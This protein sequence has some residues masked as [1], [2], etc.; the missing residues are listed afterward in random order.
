MLKKKILVTT[1]MMI[2]DESRFRSWLDRLGY[3][4]EFV[5]N[6]QFLNEDQCLKLQ[7]VYDGWIAGDDE[8]TSKVIK[9]L[10]PKL[11]IISKW[12]T[13]ID[14][15]DIDY[16]NKSQ[17]AICNTPGAFGDAVGEMAVAYLLALTRGIV[18]THLDVSNGGWPKIRRST[19]IGMNVGVIGLG[20]IGLGA[21]DRL[22]ALGCKV[23]Y[24]DPSVDSSKYDKVS[25]NSLF[26]KCDAVII[27]CNLNSS[28]LKLVD[29]EL[30]KNAKQ[31]LLLVNVARGPIVD[32][33]A[34][35]SALFSGHLSGAALD[36]FEYEPISQSNKLRKHPNVIL[37]SHNANNTK[38]AVEYV[39]QNTIQNLEVFFNNQ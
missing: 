10:L 21:A 31:G 3:E 37:G 18:S 8:I 16:A 2:N 1:Q 17:V 26:Q 25:L 6:E 19:L 9:H 22:K 14:S 15:I 29:K 5:R 27:T 36:V 30:L 35:I 23:F 32:E 20:A 7:P 33:G 24:T 38:D 34:L 11:K 4:S 13:G 39:H 12:G 28:T